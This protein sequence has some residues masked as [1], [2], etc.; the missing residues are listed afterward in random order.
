MA[1]CHFPYLPPSCWVMEMSSTTARYYSHLPRQCSWELSLIQFPPKHRDWYAGVLL[2]SAPRINT[3]EERKEEG[4]KRKKLNWYTV[5]GKASANSMGGSGV[6]WLSRIVLH[7]NNR[8]VSTGQGRDQSLD[9][10]LHNVMKE[11]WPWER[12]PSAEIPRERETQLPTLLEWGMCS[13]PGKDW[14]V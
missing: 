7:G 11:P 13:V 9:V 5:A 10:T 4:W 3:C 8:I 14:A 6:G 12:G 1:S 2:E